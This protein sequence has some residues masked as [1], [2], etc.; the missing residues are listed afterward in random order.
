M[1]DDLIL[2][3]KQGGGKGWMKRQEVEEKF[4][5]NKKNIKQAR[6]R[7]RNSELYTVKSMTK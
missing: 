7:R 5:D 6:R 1:A 3:E 4:Q 2:S